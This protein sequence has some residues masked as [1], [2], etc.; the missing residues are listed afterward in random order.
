MRIATLTII[1]IVA[2]TS[3]LQGAAWGNKNLESETTA[4][5]EFQQLRRE[6]EELRREHEQLRHEHEELR[7]AVMQLGIISQAHE[8]VIS[9][10]KA[11][12]IYR[13]PIDIW[14]WLPSTSSEILPWL[15]ALFRGVLAFILC[16]ALVESTKDK[17]WGPFFVYLALLVLL[18]LLHFGWLVAPGGLMS[19][20]ANSVPS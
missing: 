17:N 15:A 6:H 1:S 14:E 3:F 8:K 19:N 5:G 4:R 18:G 7:E 11:D 13:E 2:A 12:S 20:M 16:A 9:R 10:L